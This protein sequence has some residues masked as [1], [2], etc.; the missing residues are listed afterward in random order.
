MQAT[1]AAETLKTSFETIADTWRG[2]SPATVPFA[3]YD[4]ATVV[5]LNHPSAPDERPS[6]LYSATAIDIGGILTATVPAHWCDDESDLVPLGYHEGLHVYQAKNFTEN[7]SYDFFSALAHYPEFD[8]SY[9]AA[10]SLQA[11]IL[12]HP[13]MP[14][15]VKLRQLVPIHDQLQ[16][17]FSTPDIQQYER[18]MERQEG[19]ASYIEAK[20][21]QALFGI[22]P[23]P[24]PDNFGWGRFYDTGAAL[25]RLLDKVSD[26]WQAV[27][28]NGASLSELIYQ[29][30][31]KP[32]HTINGFDKVYERQYRRVEREKIALQTQVDNLKN[33]G[34]RIVYPK[35]IPS[36]RNFN[37]RAMHSWDGA[38]LHTQSFRLTLEGIGEVTI[39]GDFAIDDIANS[40]LIIPKS[41][42]TITQG[43]L[44]ID[45]DNLH[46]S[47]SDIEQISDTVFQIIASE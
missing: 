20:A 2:Y 47:L 38:L 32:D 30:T 4:D 13:A 11:T 22:A 15:D 41:D 6:N 27:V 36:Y 1:V 44:T 31:D 29:L 35:F 8:A 9:R 24:I 12:N 37:P 45:S 23:S 39:E 33:N 10:A 46:V 42:I 19:T 25:C 7:P 18:A 43:T 21:K 40:Q 14:V 17:S 28:E 3:V 26:N 16:R 5:Y 34:I